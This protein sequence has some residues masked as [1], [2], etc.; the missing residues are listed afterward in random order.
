LKEDYQT[1]AQYDSPE[2]LLAG[3]DVLQREHGAR[4]SS[5]S[6]LIDQIV[7]TQRSFKELTAI[8]IAVM[9]PYSVT[10]TLA[11]GLLYLCVKV[12]VPWSNLH[13]WTYFLREN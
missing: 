13:G 7:P 10:T 8:F 1:V 11:W 2:K 9:L 6:R 4:M 5:L 12:S 3:L